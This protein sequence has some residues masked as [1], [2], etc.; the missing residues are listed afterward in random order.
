MTIIE[1]KQHRAFGMMIK[2]LKDK[3]KKNEKKKLNNAAQ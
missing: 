2:M 1:R 3:K